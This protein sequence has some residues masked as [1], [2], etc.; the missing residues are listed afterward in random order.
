[1]DKDLTFILAR[2]STGGVE[3]WEGGETTFPDPWCLAI[4][5]QRDTAEASM[6]ITGHGQ[7]PSLKGLHSG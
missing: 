2:Q 6:K 7:R 3:E 1:M 4:A 5:A